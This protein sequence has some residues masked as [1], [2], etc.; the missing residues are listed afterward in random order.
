MNSD[1]N[2]IYKTIDDLDLVVN[3]ISIFELQENSYNIF[4][5]LF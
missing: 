2:E 3:V 1:N 4:I 5:S